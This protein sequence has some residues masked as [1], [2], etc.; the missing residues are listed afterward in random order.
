MTRAGVGVAGE[1]RWRRGRRIGPVGTTYRLLLAGLLGWGLYAGGGAPSWWHYPLGLVG[2]PAV[3]VAAQAAYARWR[4]PL[5]PW[6]GPFAVAGI[7]IPIVAAAVYPGT[8][9][10][11]VLM[12]ALLLVASAV[13]GDPDCEGTVIGNWL[14]GRTDRVACPN[15]V[16]DVAERYVRRRR[17]GRDRA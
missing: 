5:S 6:V 8:R 9:P 16:I 11:A 10:A 3:L 15:S 13:K 12:V 1:V 17:L 7:G 2:F 4:R 14:L